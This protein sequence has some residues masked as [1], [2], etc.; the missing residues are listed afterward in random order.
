MVINWIV[1]S[2]LIFL[3]IFVGIGMWSVRKSTKTNE[4]YL[5]AGKDVQPWLVGLSA[6]ATSNSGFMFIAMIGWTYESGIAAIWF[7]LG[8]ILGDMFASSFIHKRIRQITEKMKVL[9]FA[10]VLSS[11]HGTDYR[12]LRLVAGIV[13]IGFL[14]TYAAAQLSAG[15]KGLHV[16]LGWDY[17]TGALIGAVM[18]LIYCFAGGLRASIWTDAA[19]SFVMIFAMALLLYVGVMS[20]GGL[21]E[22]VSALGNVSPDYLDPFSVG[23]PIGGG[24]GVLLFVLG[25]FASG[26]GVVGQ[27]HIMVRFMAMDN[28][29]N[30]QKVRLYY[31]SWSITFF[32]LTI[33]VGLVARLILPEIGNFDSELALPVMAQKLLPEFLVGI[34]LAGLFAATMSTA[35]SQVL[36]CSA[37]VTQDLYFFKTHSYWKTKIA[38]LCILIMAFLIAIFAGASVFAL[39][40]LA[41]TGLASAFA[42]LLTVYVLGERPSEKMAL[43]M[44]SSGVTAMLV[45]YSLELDNITNKGLIG[46]VTGFL[47]FLLGKLMRKK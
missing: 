29:D 12:I 3:S 22:V 11:W 9:S 38:T 41:W 4:D 34:V 39:V 45:W 26:F 15:G 37:A 40:I 2:F 18:I 32:L 7:A 47:V 46:I 13:I 16:L 24:L 35:D 27:P 31:Y 8:H 10:G 30:I 25:W 36:S 20:V 5:L 14:G 23:S 43:L 6:V 1:I 21:N 19:Q 28:P 44:M 17:D 42:P 33:C